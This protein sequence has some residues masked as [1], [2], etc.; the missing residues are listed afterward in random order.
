MKSKL[1]ISGGDIHE[2]ISSAVGKST[3]IS[4]TRHVTNYDK[5]SFKPYR[6][7]RDSKGHLLS[8]NLHHSDLSMYQESHVIQSEQSQLFEGSPTKGQQSLPFATKKR[9]LMA[10]TGRK[11]EK[12]LSKIAKASSKKG[13]ADVGGQLQSQ[14]SQRQ[15]LDGVIDFMSKQNMHLKL[16]DIPRKNRIELM[17]NGIQGI[18]AET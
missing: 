15:N 18:D 1:L 14:F 17:M 16:N 2:G 12:H 10:M 7:E 8:A 13:D 6:V 11:L 5:D 4:S 3:Q 9:D